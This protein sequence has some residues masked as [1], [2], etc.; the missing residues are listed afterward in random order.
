MYRFAACFEHFSKN[1]GG[2][3][4]TVGARNGIYRRRAQFKKQFHLRADGD[5]PLP[6]RFK[7][8]QI[9]FHARGAEDQLRVLQPVQ[10]RLS[11]G[12]EGAGLLQ[13]VRS[14]AQLL[15]RSFIAGGH[16]GAKPQQLQYH[17][18]IVVADSAHRDP[19][20]SKPFQ[21]SLH[22]VGFIHDI[23]VVSICHP[24]RTLPSDLSYSSCSAK[25][26]CP[27]LEEKPAFGF[28]YYTDETGKYQ[29]SDVKSCLSL[30]LLPFY[31]KGRL[32]NC[33]N[34]LCSPPSNGK[35]VSI[36]KYSGQAVERRRIHGEIRA[37]PQRKLR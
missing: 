1:G 28:I 33:M 26:A 9:G 31:R 2:G 12:K 5:S 35:M 23:G 11:Q 10:V 8:R 20:A 21:K 30:T 15:S 24:F 27:R 6:R 4:F 32:T 29:Q 25:A 34:S 36:E 14:V 7:G 13:P 3:G 17:R 37:D 18:R 22:L 16:P 19:F